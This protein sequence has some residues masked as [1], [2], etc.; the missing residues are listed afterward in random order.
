MARARRRLGYCS[1]FCDR[2]GLEPPVNGVDRVKARE[3][4]LGTEVQPVE[5]YFPNHPRRSKLM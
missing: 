5:S 3:S 1:G 2:L 4:E